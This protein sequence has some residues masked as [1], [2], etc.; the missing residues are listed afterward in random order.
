MADELICDNEQGLV[1]EQ[2]NQILEEEEDET[3]VDQGDMDENLVLSG[4]MVK[5]DYD[6][7]EEQ[8]MR[9]TSTSQFAFGNDDEVPDEGD[10]FGQISSQEVISSR[11]TSSL[12]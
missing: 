4:P 2:M 9:P 6:T 10:N 7:T 1:Q 5:T 11:L 3:Y 8:D 12:R